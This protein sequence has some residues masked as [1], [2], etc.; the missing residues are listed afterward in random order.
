MLRG[1]LSKSFVWCCALTVG[2]AVTA[3]SYGGTVASPWS[4]GETSR[5][6]LR[7]AAVQMPSAPPAMP[8]ASAGGFA[9]RLL[10]DG[11]SVDQTLSLPQLATPTA[12]T[13][14][15]PASVSN[16]L[17]FSSPE[18]EPPKR[19][20]SKSAKYEMA[21]IGDDEIGNPLCDFSYLSLGP[22][23]YV[24]AR[25][26]RPTGDALKWSHAPETAL[27]Y[28]RP[29]RNLQ[30]GFQIDS[31]TGRSASA[32]DDI[33]STSVEFVDN[34]KVEL[35]SKEL[36]PYSAAFG[37]MAETATEP[38]RHPGRAFSIGFSLGLLPAAIA[39][40]SVSATVVVGVSNN[41]G[42]YVSIVTNIEVPDERVQETF[43]QSDY[44]PPIVNLVSDAGRQVGFGGGG[45]ADDE[46]T[47][48]GTE[49]GGGG[50][51]GGEPDRTK[52][53][54]K[55]VPEPVPEPTTM[56]LFGAGL[57]MLARRRHGKRG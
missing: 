44:L 35:D 45:V 52:G 16:S 25:S 4:D 55:I 42:P 11:E 50:G 28:V 18:I 27:S 33:V 15:R 38:K 41:P 12:A 31:E 26:G 24:M 37:Q 57:A 40:S 23:L 1:I 17:I 34:L 32:S 2:A 30:V 7:P 9:L 5:V 39:D 14:S 22:Q 48:G 21:D 36:L 8:A 51:G 29:H 47:P 13:S 56:L 43:E 54:I 49:G 20:V 6:T 10:T 3:T 19:K 46:D 53:K